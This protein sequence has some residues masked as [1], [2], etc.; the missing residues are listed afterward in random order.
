MKLIATVRRFVGELCV[1]VIG[2]PDVTAR[3]VVAT[4]EL[5]DNAVRYGAPQVGHAPDEEHARIQVVVRRINDDAEVSIDT[6]NR[7][8]V[9]SS[10]DQQ[11]A[12][13]ER[14]FEAMRTHSERDRRLPFYRE[15]LKRAAQREERS[16][17]GL[18]RVHA[19]SEMNLS[20]RFA[21]GLFHVRAE[22]LFPVRVPRRS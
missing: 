21:D 15:L 2:D 9:A 8:E 17:L 16:G 5:L 18:G 6:T 14:L 10:T 12:D 11:L 22:G 3:V 4:H 1:R 19:E 7:I 20:S 13:L